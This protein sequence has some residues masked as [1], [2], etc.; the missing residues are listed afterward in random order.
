MRFALAATSFAAIAAIPLAV[1]AAGPRMSGE[2]F[3]DSVRCVVYQ[4]AAGGDL[5]AAKSE[6]NREARRQSA[7]IVAEALDA[8]RDGAAGAGQFGAGCAVRSN[9][10]EA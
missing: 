9:G 5:R 1:A 3:V 8:V 7:E 2:Q 4:D 6:L 10:H